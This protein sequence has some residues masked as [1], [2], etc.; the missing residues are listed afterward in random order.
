MSASEN[1][2]DGVSAVASNELLDFGYRPLGVSCKHCGGDLW[3]RP[4]THKNYGVVV[5]GFEPMLYV[6]ANGDVRCPPRP[7]PFAE[8]YDHC[9]MYDRYRKQS[10]AGLE[11]R[12]VASRAPCAC[13]AIP[14]EVG[15]G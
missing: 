9:G 3:G 5:A 14:K 4:Q 11:P 10:N 12:A 15:R 7:S 1:Q 13:S 2:A 8:P 6:H